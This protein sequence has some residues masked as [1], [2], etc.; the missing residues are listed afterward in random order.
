MVV[1][2]TLS[3]PNVLL[4]DQARFA[5]DD[6]PL[7]SDTQEILRIDG[8]VRRRLGYQAAKPQ[9]WVVPKKPAEHTVTVEFTVYS[10]IDYAE[11]FL[12][13]EDATI[14][15]I[16]WNGETVE[17]KVIGYYTD[18]SIEK[19]ALPP[20]H[21]GENTLR[22]TYPFA[23]RSNCEA[24]YLL[25][26]FGVRVTGRMLTVTTL[27]EKLGFSDLTYQGLPFYGG[28][29]SYHIPVECGEETEARISVPHYIAAVNTVSV[30]GERRATVAY[31]PYTADIGR[32][33][34]GKNEVTVTAFISRRNC[35]GDVHNADER[36][37]WQGPIAW[38]T[39]SSRWTYEY[40]LRRTGLLTAPTVLKL[41]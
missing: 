6:A 15:T 41:H 33:P 32:L 11:P 25:G 39:G 21:K 30:N 4:L 29:V 27:P 8:S 10:E 12:A 34:A 20:L 1:D 40:R 19:V 9:P 18:R 24:M 16:L 31:P 22:V 13:L 7:S 14:S 26:H 23:E 5:L 2:Y 38:T 35:F 28:E 36:F 37:S 17:N 3:E